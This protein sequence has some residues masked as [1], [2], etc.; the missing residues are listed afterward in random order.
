M[1]KNL[2]IASAIF[3]IS[4]GC[5]SCSNEWKCKSIYRDNIIGRWKLIEVSVYI[6]YAHLEYA[7]LDTTDYSKE[8]IIFDFQENNKLVVI[9]K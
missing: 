5:F 1:K 7:Q 6:K 3:L 9:G 2:F 8:N 4:A